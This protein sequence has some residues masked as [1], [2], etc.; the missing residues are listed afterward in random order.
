MTSDITW[1]TSLP[2]RDDPRAAA[3]RVAS[4]GGR[5]LSFNDAAEAA[6]LEP[7]RAEVAVVARSGRAALGKPVPFLADVLDRQLAEPG[8]VFGLINADVAFEADATTRAVLLR[9]AERGL[10]CLRR[11][12]VTDPAMPLARGSQLPQGFDAFLYPRAMIPALRAEGFCLGMPFWDFWMP[13]AAVIGGWPLTFVTAPVLRHLAHPTR[14][15][16]A[17]PAFMQIFL[18]TVG[19]AAARGQAPIL[20]ALLSH[21]VAV[22]RALADLAQVNAPAEALLHGVYDDFQRRLLMVVAEAAEVEASLPIAD[23]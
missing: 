19:I 12:D 17:A 16:A 18:E 6:A 2:A 14:W 11:T 8:E 20:S 5:V 15:D 21:Q 7:G 23:L 3:Q 22:A 10:V 9:R 13:A 1:A 4:W